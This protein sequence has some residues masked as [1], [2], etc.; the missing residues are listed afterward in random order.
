[1]VW[2]SELF[3]TLMFLHMHVV[4]TRNPVSHEF[5]DSFFTLTVM[6]WNLKKPTLATFFGYNGLKPKIIKILAVKEDR[7]LKTGRTDRLRD[8]RESYNLI[9]C[10]LRIN[11]FFLKT[12]GTCILPHRRNLLGSLAVS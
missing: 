7:V 3:K 5:S 6:N 9:S 8:E 11:R 1:M 2:E 12:G 4:Q 10:M